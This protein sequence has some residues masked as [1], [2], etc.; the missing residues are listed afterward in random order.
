[1]LSVSFQQNIFVNW[2]TG[3]DKSFVLRDSS[4]EYIHFFFF[5]NPNPLT[6]T[7]KAVLSPGNE[8]PSHVDI[9]MPHRV[10]R[11]TGFA[12]IHTTMCQLHIALRDSAQ[13]KTFT[14][15]LLQPVCNHYKEKRTC[16]EPVIPKKK[17]TC[18]YHVQ[19]SI[20]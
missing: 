9:C 19:L 13:S 20:P 7:D 4:Q 6:I 3:V 12:F 18:N 1:M 2:T 15:L 17:K 10:S 8:L 5:L 16:R 11:L 14:P